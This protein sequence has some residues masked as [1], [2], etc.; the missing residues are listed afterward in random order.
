MVQEKLLTRA[1]ILREPALPLPVGN[2]CPALSCP[3]PR[4]VKGI[5]PRFL[6][7]RSRWQNHEIIDAFFVAMNG[8][9]SENLRLLQLRIDS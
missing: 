4:V 9:D 2:S 6:F 3:M 5:Q 7:D 8:G 1:N